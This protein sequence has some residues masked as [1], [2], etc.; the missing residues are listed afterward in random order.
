MKVK[1]VETRDQ[2]DPTATNTRGVK[3]IIVLEVLEYRR[4]EDVNDLFTVGTEMEITRA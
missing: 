2:L 4:H 1:T 3:R